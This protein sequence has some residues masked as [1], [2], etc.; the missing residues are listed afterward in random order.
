M[1]GNQAYFIEILKN[2]LKWF[3]FPNLILFVLW[4]LE[5]ESG[6]ASYLTLI[7]NTVFLP[8]SFLITTKSINEKHQKNWWHLNFILF[9]ILLI[10]SI[11]LNLLNWILLVER[12]GGIYGRHNIDNGTWMII[13]LE[14]TIG[15]GILGMGLLYFISLGNSKK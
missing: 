2:A 8:L 11:Y 14:L 6:F 5:S 7:F 1:K 10:A 12:D 9:S 3:V 15:F 4:Q 13:N